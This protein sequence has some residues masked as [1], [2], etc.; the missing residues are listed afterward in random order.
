MDNLFYNCVMKYISKKIGG[1]IRRTKQS[2][3]FHGRTIT[4]A[5]ILLSGKELRERDDDGAL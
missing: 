2:S 5:K 3:Q 4:C 1:K